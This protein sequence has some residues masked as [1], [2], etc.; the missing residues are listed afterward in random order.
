[1]RISSGYLWLDPRFRII[2][3]CIEIPEAKEPGLTL[4][5]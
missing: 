5:F 4:P 1:M 3:I 2:V